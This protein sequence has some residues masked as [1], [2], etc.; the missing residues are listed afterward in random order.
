MALN[1]EEQEMLKSIGVISL[2]PVVTI[3][4]DI[5]GNTAISI[6]LSASGLS[7]FYTS[8]PA[9]SHAWLIEI[10]SDIVTCAGKIH[11]ELARGFIKGDVVVFDD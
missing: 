10:G 4:N 8:G 1:K 5:D 11:S 9:E 3:K 6:A 2:K 7:F